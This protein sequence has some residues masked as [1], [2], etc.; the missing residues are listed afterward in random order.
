MTISVKR[1]LW[2]LIAI[3][4]A[5]YLLHVTL[6]S[7]NYP[8]P[9]WYE[10]IELFD[11]DR[12]ISLATWYNQLL[13]LALA[14]VTLTIALLKHK[15]ADRWTKHWFALSALMLFL[16][17]DETAMIH[18]KFGI[19]THVTG[20]HDFLITH[21]GRFFTYSW[22]LI[23]LT[24]LVIIAIFMFK[25]WRNLPTNTRRLLALSVAIFLLGSVFLDAYAGWY[26]SADPA[27]YVSHFITGAEES[28]EMIGLALALY[29]LLN[30][31]RHLPPKVLRN[32]PVTL[33]D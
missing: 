31:L 8:T 23:S 17:A 20:L 27:I 13:F 30:H 19:F 12:E 9:E 24:F 5:F 1:I 32:L 7:F 15:L 18:E 22:W 21:G 6:L 2:L 4:A 29:A 16:S 10:A 11:M 14:A 28:C 25:F 26:N 33:T 3:T